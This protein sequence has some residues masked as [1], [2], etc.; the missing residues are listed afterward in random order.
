MDWSNLLSGT[1]GALIGVAGALASTMLTINRT[2]RHDADRAAWAADAALTQA[3]QADALKVSGQLADMLILF[4]ED[5]SILLADDQQSGESL[6]TGR[7]GPSANV[8]RR[9]ITVDAP[10]LS[11][12]LHD[13]MKNARSKIKTVVGRQP[14]R[15][16]RNDLTELLS[17][18]RAA[19]ESLRQARADAYRDYGD[20][21][22]LGDVTIR[23]GSRSAAHG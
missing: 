1:I 13:Q 17:V 20:G 6:D 14:R 15:A 9:A 4:Y 5:L 11:P 10:I 12:S 7:L 18:V 23:A 8:L 19:G 21:A 22:A 3:R 2:R 16:A